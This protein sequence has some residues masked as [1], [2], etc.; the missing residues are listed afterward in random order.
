MMKLCEVLRF[1]ECKLKVLGVCKE[2]FDEEVQKPLETVRVSNPHLII[3][4]DYNDDDENGSWWWC[5]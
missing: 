5:P 4:H 1:P 3:K 2:A